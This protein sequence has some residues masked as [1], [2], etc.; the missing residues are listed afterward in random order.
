LIITPKHL[1][2]FYTG[3]KR[4]FGTSDS[5]KAALWDTLLA[6]AGPYRIE[7]KKIVISVDVSYNEIANGRPLARTWQMQGRQLT[8]TGDPQ[9]FGRDPSK[10]VVIEQKWERIE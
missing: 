6:L 5:E 2:I 9:S 7:G 8:L 1:S 3:D 10:T 4:K